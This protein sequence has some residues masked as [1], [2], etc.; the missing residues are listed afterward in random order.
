MNVP[1]QA[2]QL[3]AIV[4]TNVWADSFLGHRP[5]CKSAVEFLGLAATRNVQLL[6]PVT[7]LQD[8]FAIIILELKQKARFEGGLTERGV[9]AIRHLAWGCVDTVREIACAVGADESDA[10]LACKYRTVNWDLEDNMVIAA[11]KR[12]Q[13]DY[14]VTSDKGLIEKAP[15]A[16][17]TPADMCEVLKGAV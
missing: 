8:L 2:S 1:E 5:G 17:L 14:L 7:T 11:A 10:W 4:D 6:Y 3:K 9:H 12:M 13:V 16:A 15:V